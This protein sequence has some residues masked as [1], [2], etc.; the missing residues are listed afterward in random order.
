MRIV[1]QIAYRLRRHL[2][3]R[4]RLRTRGVKVMVFNRRGELLLIRN[5]YGN[6]NLFVLP[7]GGIGR[8][9]TPLAAAAREV[10]EEVGLHLRALAPVATYLSSAEGKRDTIHLFEGMAEAE[11]AIDGVEVEEARFFPLHALPQAVSAATMRRIAERQGARY[12]ARD[13]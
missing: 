11:P 4:L 5:S 10:L 7:G 12:R 13:W 8:R 1:L 3:A 9:E 2:L 6:R